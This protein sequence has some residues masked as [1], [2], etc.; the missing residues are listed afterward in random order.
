MPSSPT[1]Q[2]SSA[3]HAQGRLGATLPA[4]TRKG[5]FAARAVGSF[6]PKL[7]KTAFEKHGFATAEL[8]TEWQRIVGADVAAYTRPGKL[9]WPRVAGGEA[10]QGAG[11]PSATLVLLA[12][13]ARALD[14]QYKARQ[15]VDRINV[16]FGYRAVVDLRIEQTALVNAAHPTAVTADAR[17]VGQ[18]S[19]KPAVLAS[20][21]DDGLRSALERLASGLARA[22]S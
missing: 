21:S 13:P 7:T 9:R 11:R 6:V 14:V 15:I 2:S 16:Y 18:S 19:A 22:R 10:E 5:Y 8:V 4:A 3:R 17:R 20:I 1:A 12:D